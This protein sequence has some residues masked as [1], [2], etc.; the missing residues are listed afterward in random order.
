MSEHSVVCVP[1]GDEFAEF[2][3]LHET[4]EH[5]VIF[6]EDLDCPTPPSTP[7]PQ[8]EA[9]YY[10]DCK[11]LKGEIPSPTEG[12]LLKNGEPYKVIA[13]VNDKAILLVSENPGHAQTAVV[14][15]LNRLRG[16]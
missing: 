16:L 7:P 14:V 6:I 4:Y 12:R 13:T 8:L 11:K 3:E 5:P 10:W 1:M 9:I 15:P 2:V